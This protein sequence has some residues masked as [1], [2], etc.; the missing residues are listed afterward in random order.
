M[1][2]KD[3][4]NL[5][6][7]SQT[8]SALKMEVI[9]SSEKLYPP[10]IPHSVTTIDNFTAVT[11]K[12]LIYRYLF[13]LGFVSVIQTSFQTLYHEQRFGWIIGCVTSLHSS[14]RFLSVE[15]YGRKVRVC[16]RSHDGYVHGRSATPAFAL[17]DLRKS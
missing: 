7:K 4:Q 10:I 14:H 16:G 6:Q 11:T 9:C 5:Q 3:F 12:N 13:I 15:G 8:F 1:K 17:N 2:A